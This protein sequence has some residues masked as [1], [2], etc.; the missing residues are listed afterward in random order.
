[1]TDLGAALDDGSDVRLPARLARGLGTARA[2][3]PQLLQA[4]WSHPDTALRADAFERLALA[5]EERPAVAGRILG[6]L[7]VLG[8]D[9]VALGIQYIARHRARRLAL[10]IAR[11][12]RVPAMQHHAA[13]LAEVFRGSRPRGRR[14]GRIALAP[15]VRSAGPSR[16]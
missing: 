5:V 6:L 2:S 14:A 7:S 9:R 12:S 8:R 3:L 11:R 1:L 10:R 16:L 13:E 4:A 15:V